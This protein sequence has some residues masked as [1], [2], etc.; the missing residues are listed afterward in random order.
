[1]KK[2]NHHD[3][4][5]APVR[6]FYRVHDRLKTAFSGELLNPRTGEFYRPVDRT[7]Q[8]FVAECD[9]NNILKQFKATGMLTHVSAKAAQGQYIDLPDDSDFQ[10]ALHTVK[11]GADAFAS[12]PSKLRTRFENDPAKFLEFMADP[13]NQDEAIA[14]GLATDNRPPAPPEAPEISS[15][16]KK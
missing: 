7:K 9:I 11:Q 3:A 12:L 16:D 13:K 10:S 5:Q 14:L 4:P 1:M 6:S 8:S 15:P 2:D